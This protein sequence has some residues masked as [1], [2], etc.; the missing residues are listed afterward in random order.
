[1][2]HFLTR[3]SIYEGCAKI[4]DDIHGKNDVDDIIEWFLYPNRIDLNS[5]VK[6]SVQWQ[7]YTVEDRKKDNKV[8]PFFP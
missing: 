3:K 1:M 2:N 5:V 8:V 4:N 6:C 7:F